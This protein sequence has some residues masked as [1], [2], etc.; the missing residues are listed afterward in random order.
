VFCASTR[1]SASLCIL[2]FTF[3]LPW[4]AEGQTSP[5]P[6]VRVSALDDRNFDRVA[7]LPELRNLALL[8]S[9][10]CSLLNKQLQGK[11]PTVVI[12]HACLLPDALSVYE[13]A[14]LRLAPFGASLDEVERR[15]RSGVVLTTSRSRDASA[16]DAARYF[17]ARRYLV[18]ALQAT[19]QLVHQWFSP[20][21]ADFFKYVRPQIHASFTRGTAIN[22]A[23]AF[24]SNVNCDTGTCGDPA[25][26]AFLRQ[27]TEPLR[28]IEVDSTSKST[29]SSVIV[30]T[31]LYPFLHP[32]RV[33]EAL[34][35]LSAVGTDPEI[36]QAVI[37]D[38][39]PSTSNAQQVQAAVAV[40]R[41]QLLSGAAWVETDA[42]SAALLWIDAA[43][44]S[45]DTR[46]AKSSPAPQEIKVD[47]GK[48]LQSVAAQNRD[49]ALTISDNL[50]R[51]RA[52]LT[53]SSSLDTAGRR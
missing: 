10:N 32:L 5:M 36:L 50:I 25:L 7:I 21:A 41:K 47:V 40:L 34:Q 35:N 28:M 31:A 51:L 26:A 33:N 20:W 14:L 49:V 2:L 23:H 13:I 46:R 43:A 42:R 44:T 29:T 38:R 48:H 52:R 8:V 3:W 22:V 4:L 30:S 24:L 6:A 53:W 15:L 9:E 27:S 18:V 12:R 37:R 39:P 19:S 1:A 17:L 11:L 16:D 45:V